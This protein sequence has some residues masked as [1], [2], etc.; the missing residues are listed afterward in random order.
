MFKS[1]RMLPRSTVTCDQLLRYARSQAY[2]GDFDRLNAGPTRFSAGA[3]DIRTGNFIY[4]DTTTH[5]ALGS[6]ITRLPR[7]PAPPV[8]SQIWKQ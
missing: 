6:A 1:N 8:Y 4:F 5:V 3:V 2:P 7:R